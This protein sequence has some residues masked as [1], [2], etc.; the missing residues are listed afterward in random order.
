MVVTAQR[1][2]IVAN[3]V[4]LGDKMLSAKT[5]SMAIEELAKEKF[6]ELYVIDKVVFYEKKVNDDEIIFIFTLLKV[7]FIPS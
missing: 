7:F 2:T 5:M 1:R 3:I 4:Y 6:E